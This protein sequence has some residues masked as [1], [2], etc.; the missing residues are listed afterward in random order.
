M[1]ENGFVQIGDLWL[2]PDQLPPGLRRKFED[3]ARRGKNKVKGGET[4]P[5]PPKKNFWPDYV[6]RKGGHRGGDKQMT[7]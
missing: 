4:P 6:W 3:C 7:V 2:R 1:D 5:P